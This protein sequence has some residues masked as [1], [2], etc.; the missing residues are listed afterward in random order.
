MKVEYFGPAHNR[1]I[2]K[3]DRVLA[4]DG[5]RVTIS[6][7]YHWTRDNPVLD[8][9]PEDEEAMRLLVR[10]ADYGFREPNARRLRELGLDT[11]AERQADEAKE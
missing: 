3:G 5:T 8:V 9:A 2:S 10:G 1:I 11:E 7:N 4:P 6:H